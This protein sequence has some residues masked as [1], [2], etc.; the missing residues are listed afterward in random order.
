MIDMFQ[1]V[2]CA[3]NPINFVLYELLFQLL[4]YCLMVTDDS[5]FPILGLKFGCSQQKQQHSQLQLHG[6]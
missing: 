2:S 1:Y 5:L 3:G 6:E 4:N